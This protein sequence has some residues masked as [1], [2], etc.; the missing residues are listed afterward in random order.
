MG[1][2]HV[3]THYAQSMRAHTHTHQHTHI[4]THSLHSKHTLKDDT[5]KEIGDN[6]NNF[7]HV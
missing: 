2:K 6:K 4:H 5:L 7:V 1:K 3:Y